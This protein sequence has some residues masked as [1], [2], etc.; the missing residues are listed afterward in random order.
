MTIQKK[1]VIALLTLSCFA[2]II[3]LFSSNDIATGEAYLS[4]MGNGTADMST[5][6]F[7]LIDLN[8]LA[9]VSTPLKMISSVV[10]SLSVLVIILTYR[11]Y[12]RHYKK[13][14]H[15]YFPF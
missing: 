6:E 8:F 11:I 9:F 7:N 5:G 13:Q 14:T 1:S 15:K 12:R 2:L 10:A 4:V 3:M